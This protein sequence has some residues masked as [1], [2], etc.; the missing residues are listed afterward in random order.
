MQAGVRVIALCAGTSGGPTP[1]IRWGNF[2]F[3]RNGEI[4]PKTTNTKRM[5]IDDRI[6]NAYQNNVQ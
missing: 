5:H 1:K 6:T 2:V 3:F 4:F